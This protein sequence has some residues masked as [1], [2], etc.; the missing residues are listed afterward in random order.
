[1]AFGNPFSFYRLGNDRKRIAFIFTSL[2][3]YNCKVN[4]YYIIKTE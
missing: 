2:F 3:N 4:N 1:M